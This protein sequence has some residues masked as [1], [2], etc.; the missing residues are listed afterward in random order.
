MG[1][2]SIKD[3]YQGGYSSLSPK[4][5]SSFGNY[6]IDIKTFGMTT[7]PRTANIIQEASNKLNTGARH[8]EISAIGPAEFE[9]IPKQQFEELRRLGKII[10]TTASVHG[11]IIELSGLTQQQ[12][13]NANREGAE[14][15]ML[16]AVE[17]AHMI[18]PDGNISVTFHSSAVSLPGRSSQK[19]VDPENT[20]IINKDT[21]SIHTIPLKERT[22][23]GEVKKR[24]PKQ[25]IYTLNKSQ[26]TENLRQL[27]YR[28]ELGRD[29]I[30]RSAITNLL[31]ESEKI[32][33][34]ELT[35]EEENMQYLFGRGANYIKS[36]YNELKELFDVAYH[37]SSELERNKIK[38]FYK[39]IEKDVKKIS[40]DPN[41]INN[42]LI[43]KDIV[44]KGTSFLDKEITAPQIYGD[45]N[46]FAMEK[47]TET[48]SNVALKS[49]MDKNIGNK[50]VNKTPII[51]IENPP[52][53]M[54][55]SEGQDLRNIVETSRQKFVEKAVKEGMNEKDARD[56]ASKLI[57]VTWDVGHINML[58]KYGYDS[59]DLIKETEKVAPLVK[60]IH[61]SDN[62]G[63][64]HTELPMGMGNVPMKEILDKIGKDGFDAKKIIEAGNW[65]QHFQTPP[66][67]ETL[68]AFGSPIYSMQMAPYWNQAVALQQGYYGGY[69]AM[70][71]Q[72]NYES[73]G[74]GFSRLP[75]ELGGQSPGAEGTRMSNKP[76]E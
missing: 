76:M 14:R 29:A 35:K 51:N 38:N 30:E 4:Y 75:M 65:W 48:I 11:P 43:I 13:S 64:E 6:K 22:F 41:D 37:N 5:N 72:T 8:I 31:A 9:S 55:F 28:S 69:G 36:S 44:R 71:P 58:R 33:K 73:F 20:L 49:L 46:E 56:A 66:F 21:G 17:K 19:G 16:S 70:L 15:Q 74:A 50:N 10:G 68:E 52:A 27:E 7:D 26:W 61:L 59:K 47:T 63:F 54:I 25:E 32:N 67:K 12:F 34:K 2:Y 39:E 57:G 40:N 23:P 24:D 45:L 53:G 1:D 42:P 62:F 18:N 60:H 3:I